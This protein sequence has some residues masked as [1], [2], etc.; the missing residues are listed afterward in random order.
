MSTAMAGSGEPD[1]LSALIESLPG[2]AFVIDADGGVRFAT[3]SAEW[4][5]YHKDAHTSTSELAALALRA[6]P[7]LLVLYH[8]LYWGAKD[9]DLIQEIRA[10]G[11]PGPVISARD[12]GIY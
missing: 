10:A 11:Y 12:L 9:D 6:K 8:Q 1:F 4:Q 3:R 7:K 5:R 2:A